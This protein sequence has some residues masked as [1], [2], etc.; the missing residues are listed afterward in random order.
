MKKNEVHLNTATEIHL[1]GKMIYISWEMIFGE[2]ELYTVFERWVWP[3]LTSTF[4]FQSG[5]EL[6]FEILSP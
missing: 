2:T 5:W 1:G 4:T 6:H 3:D